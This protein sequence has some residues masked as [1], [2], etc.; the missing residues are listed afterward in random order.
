VKR[1]KLFSLVF[2]TLLFDNMSRP[3]SQHPNK[4]DDH[5]FD[6]AP[7]VPWKPAAMVT[8]ES[9]RAV[10]FSSPDSIAF[11][12]G[13]NK[14]VPAVS[15]RQSHPWIGQPACQPWLACHQPF[16]TPIG[17]REVT[18]DKHIPNLSPIAIGPSHLM[19]YRLSIA[20]NLLPL[21]API[22]ARA[23][24]HAILRPGGWKT[25]LYSLTQQDI[26]LSE[27]P[28]AMSLV[29]PLTN[30]CVEAVR[31]LYGDTVRMDL[32]QPHIL[33]YD[34]NHKGV[35]LHRDRCDVT[36]QLMLSAPRD[37]VGGGTYF[38][39]LGAED[40]SMATVRLERGDLLLHPGKLVHAGRLITS[41]QRYLLVWFC[42]V[43]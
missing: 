16:S 25:E 29:Q 40:D 32:N 13:V 37:Y 4:E 11:E 20:D 21:L 30:V 41:G 12:N 34:S 31:Q 27:I 43:R 7:A 24:E 33:K 2:F 8:A 35:V 18:F 14:A 23:E 5:P 39:D 36:A 17:I 26:P 15:Y 10:A 22:V 3:S 42:H 1:R 38:P 19:I 28:G 9:I 6:E